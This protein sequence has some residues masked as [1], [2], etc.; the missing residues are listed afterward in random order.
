MRVR[1][2]MGGYVGESVEGF[3]VIYEG[4]GLGFFLLGLCIDLL[5]R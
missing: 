3:M 1:G 4:V 2:W 5:F